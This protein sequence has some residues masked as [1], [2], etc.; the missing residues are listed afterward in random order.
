MKKAEKKDVVKED[1]SQ[2]QILSQNYIA[3]EN[4]IKKE[5]EKNLTKWK[6]LKQREKSFNI[7]D[8]IKKSRGRDSSMNN[9]MNSHTSSNWEA[10]NGFKTGKLKS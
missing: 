8:V 6:E 4:Q 10:S 7:R 1:D 9:G 5:N 3:S 2:K